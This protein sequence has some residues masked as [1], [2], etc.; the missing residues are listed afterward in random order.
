MGSDAPGSTGWR[1]REDRPVPETWGGRGAQ[2]TPS[3]VSKKAVEGSQVEDAGA[4]LPG[5][6]PLTL[7]LLEGRP[8]QVWVWMRRPVVQKSQGCWPAREE[9]VPD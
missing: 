8:A 5:P 9:A 3:K 7:V 4:R 2:T 6:S 1:L